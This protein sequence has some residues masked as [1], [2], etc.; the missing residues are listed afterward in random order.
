MLTSKQNLKIYNYLNGTNRTLTSKQAVARFGIRN[1]RARMTELRQSGLVVVTSR[2]RE[3]LTRY[4]LETN[5][6]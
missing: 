6:R 5:G 3:G 1:L 2:N 4:A